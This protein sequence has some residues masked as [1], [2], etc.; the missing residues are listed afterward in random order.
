M[1][2]SYKTDRCLQW[3]YGTYFRSIKTD[4]K[5][6][7]SWSTKVPTLATCLDDILNN[8]FDNVFSKIKLL[9]SLEDREKQQIKLDLI[10]CILD[11]FFV[12]KRE[13]QRPIIELCKTILDTCDTSDGRFIFHNTLLAL[14]TEHYN[15]VLPHGI[16]GNKTNGWLS[17][18]ALYI[19]KFYPDLNDSAFDLLSQEKPDFYVSRQDVLQIQML[20]YLRLNRLDLYE[21]CR[22]Y[23]DEKFLN[24]MTKYRAKWLLQ[25]EIESLLNH[26]N[27]ALRF[28]KIHTM[29]G[30]E[31]YLC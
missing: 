22:S 5:L 30:K 16:L 19:L 12:L 15:V 14:N 25:A 10:T 2:T 26:T 7:C 4:Q 8:N 23:F 6:Q 1:T 27:K 18:L 13:I 21:K 11:P 28:K 17:N 31:S 20:A 29:I 3:A 24:N 9:D